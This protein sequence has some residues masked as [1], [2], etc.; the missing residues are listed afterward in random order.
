MGSEMCIR[1]RKLQRILNKLVAWG[2]TAELKFNEQKTVVIHFTKSRIKPK[3]FIKMNVKNIEYS[4]GCT[5]LG[6]HID[7]KLNWNKHIEEKI[8]K[9]KRFLMKTVHETRA[10]FGPK[11]SLMKWGY[12]GL[13]RPI[14]TYGAMIWGHSALT[15]TNIAKLRRLNRIATNTITSIRNQT[16]LEP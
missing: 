10:N 3:H 16:P 2:E 11:P 9:C 13:V 7:S 6:L 15:Q 5:Y 4:T 8:N 1:D 14:L 12:T